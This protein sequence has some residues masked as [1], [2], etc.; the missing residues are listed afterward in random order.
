MGTGDCSSYD[1][2]ECTWY[3]CDQL[4][5]VPEFLGNATDWLLNA[6]AQGLPTGDFPLDGAVVVYAKDDGYSE[7]GHVA[8]VTA[9]HPDGTFTVR[10][11]NFTG[12]DEVDYR[13]SNFYDVEGF[14]Y[15]PGTDTSG[16]G[17][18]QQGGPPQQTGDIR[19]AWADLGWI[20][21]RSIPD[22]MNRF[23]DIGRFADSEPLG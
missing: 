3:V 5:W 4:P 18:Q 8:I 12:F 1:W 16:G 14:I 17:G 10:E 23:D 21:E 13:V 11:M 20:F 2:G 15:P 6:Q 19:S 9:V 22:A 7:W